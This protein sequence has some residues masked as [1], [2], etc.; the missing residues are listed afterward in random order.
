MIDVVDDLR[1]YIRLACSGGAYYDCQT[2]LSARSNRLDLDRSKA[3]VIMFRCIAEI[4]SAGR[5]AIR[6]YL[7]RL[8]NFLHRLD[9]I[10]STLF[11]G[12]RLNNRG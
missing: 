3:D 6:G 7:D 4:R 9:I 10:T 8:G 1:G 11:R 12:S 5:W 2:W